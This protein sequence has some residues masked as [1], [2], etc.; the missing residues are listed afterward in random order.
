MGTIRYCSKPETPAN[1]RAKAE[2]RENSVEQNGSIQA[3]K[4]KNPEWFLTI[5][6]V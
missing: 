3:A 1:P 4:A 2:G 5:S 6:R